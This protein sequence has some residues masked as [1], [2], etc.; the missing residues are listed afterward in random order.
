[1]IYNLVLFGNDL[2]RWQGVQVMNAGDI[3]QVQASATG[4]TITVSGGEAV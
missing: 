4:A 3:L 2:Y 1:L